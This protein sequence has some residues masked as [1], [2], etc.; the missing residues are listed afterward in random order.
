MD[1]TKTLGGVDVMANIA[2]KDL[3]VAK[4]FYAGALGLTAI[5]S[6][7]DEAITF[8]S[9]GS[10][11]I[12]Y[13]TEFAG[14]NKATS[15]TWDVG[16]AGI[17]KVVQGLNSKGVK[18]EHYDIPNGKHEGDVHVTGPLKVAWF[19]DPDGNTLCV[20]SRAGSID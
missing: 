18:F 11:V 20:F 15:M 7:G 16:A 1:E 3:G 9:G 14:T 12:V 6:E 17:E 13:R 5:D 19:K 4:A 10:K 8:A 2:V